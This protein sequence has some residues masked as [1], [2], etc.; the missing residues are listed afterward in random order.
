MLKLPLFL[1]LALAPGAAAQ[2]VPPEVEVTK[3]SAK[4][5]PHIEEDET[6]VG[7]ETELSTLRAKSASSEE[8]ARIRISFKGKWYRGADYLAREKAAALGA[9]YLVLLQSAGSEDLGAGAVRAYKA[10]RLLNFNQAPLYIR[11]GERPPA[12][13]QSAVPARDYAQPAPADEVKTP[14]GGH[15]HFS[16]AWRKNAYMLSHVAV[17][18]PAGAGKDETEEL[19]SYVRENLP[20]KYYTKLLR[21]LKKRN[22]ITVDFGNREIR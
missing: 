11:P 2:W 21:A 18:D 5:Y 22:R 15:Q 4:E 8:I 9:N 16:W 17:F 1:V 20:G 12:P 19:K 7:T 6:S 14:A 13:Q 10:V 3:I